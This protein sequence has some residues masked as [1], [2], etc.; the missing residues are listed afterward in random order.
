MKF[1]I[2]EIWKKVKE[3]RKRLDSCEGIHNFTN[4]K[5][6][7]IVPRYSTC[8]KCKGELDP[9]HVNWYIKGVEHGSK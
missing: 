9:I 2:K 5:D 7:K 4:D 3:N 1:N 6:G 8:T